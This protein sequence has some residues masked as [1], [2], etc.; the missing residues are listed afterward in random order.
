MATF[1]E[2]TPTERDEYAQRRQSFA[3]RLR[4]EGLD[5]LVPQI[6]TNLFGIS[7]DTRL[8]PADHA[9]L[10]RLVELGQPMAVFI[11]PPPADADPDAL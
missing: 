2:L 10:A 5:E 1:D 6:D 7:V 11:A 3:Q 4:R 9:D 8:S